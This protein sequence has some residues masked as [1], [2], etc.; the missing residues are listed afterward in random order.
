MSSQDIEC[1]KHSRYLKNEFINWTSGNE[2]ID[3]FIQEMQLKV[4]NT[5]FEWIPY[6]QFNEIKETGKN[7]FMTIYSA[8]W[9]NDPLHYNNWG[10]EYMSN[11][12]K[13]VALKI[14][15]N[16]QNPVE[17]VINEVK[18]YSTKN[19]S[20]LILDSNKEVGLKIL[21]NLQN[22]IEFVI[23]EVKRYSTKNESFLMLYG[24]SQTIWKDGP[25]R[26]V[27]DYTRDSNKEV[28]LKLLHNSQ[29]SVEFIINEAKKYSTK[30]ESFHI[31]Y[32][33]SQCTDTKD[34]ILVQNNSITLTNWI[35]GNEKIDVFIQ[36][37]QLEIKDHHDVAFEWIPYSQFNEIKETD[38]NSSIT[39]NSAIWKN[40]PLYWNIRHE[41]Y[42]RDPNKEVALKC[43]HNSQ[44]PESLVSEVKKSEWKVGPLEY[45]VNNKIYKRDPNRVIALKCLHNSQNI[46]NE[47]LN[48]VKEYSI[49]KGTTGRQPF[50]DYAHDKFLAFDICNGNIPEIKEPEAPECYIKLM[51]KCWDSNLNNRPNVTEVEEFIS[52]LLTSI[53]NAEN[54]ADNDEIKIQFEEAEV[55][56][57]AIL[58]SIEETT[59]PHH[60]QAIYISRLLNPLTKDLNSECLDCAI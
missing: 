58:L 40:G 57:K 7:N 32:G 50:A 60:P 44:N 53:Y 54:D 31:L 22:P 1:S 11:S 30:N 8:I 37:M 55:F 5:I 24:I 35:S 48:E 17:F 21:H 59:H 34:C 38:K 15:H 56:R 33:I 12:N 4:E 13:V 25:L 23:N 51:K 9:K 45:D 36:E 6:S 27:G 46:T 26:Y 47:F 16:L 19:E 29:N 3:D 10:D 18:K 28:V 20:F 43:L 39:V 14:L 41:E 52:L 49:A 42:I 2:R